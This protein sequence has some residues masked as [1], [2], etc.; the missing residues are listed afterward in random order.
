MIPASGT[1]TDLLD[2]GCFRRIGRASATLLLGCALG[3]MDP[4]DEGD[5][6]TPQDLQIAGRVLHFVA[7]PPTGSVVLAIVYTRDVPNSR[8]EA[9]DAAALLAGGLPASDLVLH[10]VLAEQHDLAGLD[11]V[12]A[13]VTAD[14]VSAEPVRE[15]MRRR[16]VPCLTVHLS[17]VKDGGCLVGIRSLP[18][19]SIQLNG[20]AAG[21]VGV[22]FAT[23]FRM[24]VQEQ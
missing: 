18:S 12:A 8:R 23:A 16:H 3:G 14:G 15:A 20:D 11:P 9:T 10:A 21:A 5:R 4:A 19:V 13:L 17:Q 2:G 7:E 6:L 1:G 24:M 22:R